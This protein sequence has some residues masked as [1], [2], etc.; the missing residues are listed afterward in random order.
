MRRDR[1]RRQ[2]LEAHQLAARDNRLEHPA[3]LVRHQNQVHVRR[4]LLQRLQ[5]PVRHLVV[6]RVHA[7][8]H[9][10]AS[11]RLERRPVGRV[12]HR[13]LHVIDPH[14]VRAARAHPGQIGMRPVHHARAHG[15][16]I[17]RPLGQ[18]LRRERPRHRPLPGPRRPVEQIRV[19][20]L[21]PRPATSTAPSAPAGGPPSLRASTVIPVQPPPRPGRRR[22]PRRASGSRRCVASAP[23]RPRSAARTPRPPPPAARSPS[24]SKRSLSPAR[25]A[26]SSGDRSSRKVRSGFSPRVAKLVHPLDVVDPEPARAALVGQRRI[27]EAVRHHDLAGHPA[28]AGSRPPRARSEPPRTAAPRSRAPARSSGSFNSSRSRS[29]AGV[30]PGSRTPSASSPRAST[31]SPA[32]VV[33]PERSM[34]SKVTNRPRISRGRT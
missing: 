24:S 28:R 15:V 27:Q 5:Q 33:L 32:C 31:S 18:Q 16:R 10:H 13:A 26:A 30:P 20:G 4:R 2:R 29:P 9:E 7:L 19:R 25:A 23:G 6:H 34:P 17:V 8:Q 14:H 11:A 21:R 12:H 22:G 1:R 3:Q